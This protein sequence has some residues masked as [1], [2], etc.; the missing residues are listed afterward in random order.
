MPEACQ[1]LPR[2]SEIHYVAIRRL[3]KKDTGHNWKVAY[4]VPQPSLLIS[5]ELLLSTWESRPQSTPG[6]AL[7]WRGSF[8]LALLASNLSGRCLARLGEHIEWAELSLHSRRGTDRPPARVARPA[9][10]DS[11]SHFPHINTR[12]VHIISRVVG[13]CRN[14]DRTN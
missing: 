14:G 7:P 12:L 2:R 5:G 13:R 9:V 1:R 3:R 8:R 6:E 11:F 4:I 10:L